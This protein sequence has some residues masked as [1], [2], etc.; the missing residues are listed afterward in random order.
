MDSGLE[1]PSHLAIGGFALKETVPAFS[2]FRDLLSYI[3][4]S[5]SD[6][7]LAMNLEGKLESGDARPMLTHGDLAPHNITVDKNIGSEVLVIKAGALCLVSQNRTLISKMFFSKPQLELMDMTGKVVFVTGARYANT[8]NKRWLTKSQR[9][10]I[11]YSTVKY[12]YLGARDE[13]KVLDALK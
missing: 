9:H 10:G 6:V 5:A 7:E 4:S 12:L 3:L 13:Q 2:S 11:G 8:T 1:H